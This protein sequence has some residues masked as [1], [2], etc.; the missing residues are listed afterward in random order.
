MQALSITDSPVAPH[1]LS[2][3]AKVKKIWQNVPATL[4]WKP[5]SQQQQWHGRWT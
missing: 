5:V 2:V 1:L 3:L 4:M